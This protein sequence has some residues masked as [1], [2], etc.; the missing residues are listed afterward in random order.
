MVIGGYNFV[1]IFIRGDRVMFAFCSSGTGC[2][3][4]SVVNTIS[5][6]GYINHRQ[7]TGSPLLLVDLK[8]CYSHTWVFPSVRVVSSVAFIPGFVMFLYH[9]F[10]WMGLWFFSESKYFCHFA[11]QQNCFSRNY[12]FLYENNFF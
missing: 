3:V 2:I 5:Q 8:M 10:N 4:L 11:A 12:F 6:Q 9:P 1:Y 7:D